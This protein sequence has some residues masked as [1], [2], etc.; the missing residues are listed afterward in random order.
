[1]LQLVGLDRIAAAED[2]YRIYW[3]DIA[4]RRIYTKQRLKL[5]IPQELYCCRLVLLA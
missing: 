5:L 3:S 1:M 4:P 2:S